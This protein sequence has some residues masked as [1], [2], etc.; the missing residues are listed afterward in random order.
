MKIKETIMQTNNIKLDGCY[1]DNDRK[2]IVLSDDV[3]N[4]FQECH[5][6]LMNKN[7]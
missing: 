6:Y 2:R 5:Q 7:K 1:F 4:T 3:K